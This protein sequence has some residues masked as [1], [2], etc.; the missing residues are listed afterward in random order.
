[1]SEANPLDHGSVH[2]TSLEDANERYR[3]DG[4]AMLVTG[5]ALS[6]RVRPG[7]TEDDLIAVVVYPEEPGATS[8]ALVVDLEGHPVW[9]NP[10]NEGNSTAGYIAAAFGAMVAQR[11][12]QEAYS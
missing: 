12:Q 6:S 10:A 3:M 11:A 7:T 2:I 9:V 5:R 4:G 8:I 1:M